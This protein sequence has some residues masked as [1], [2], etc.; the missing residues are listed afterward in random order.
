MQIMRGIL[1]KLQS[2]RNQFFYSMGEHRWKRILVLY[3][4]L[5]I[6]WC[7]IEWLTIG[8]LKPN[9]WH[10]IICLAIAAIVERSLPWGKKEINMEKYMIAIKDSDLYERGF[11]FKCVIEG[12]KVTLDNDLCRGTETI[13]IKQFKNDFKKMSKKDFDLFIE[14]SIEGYDPT[15]AVLNKYLG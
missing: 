4:G 6:Y 3:L 5:A 11:C 1:S 15:E 14:L 9:Y 13:S 10:D 7:F 8:E 2:L 12:D